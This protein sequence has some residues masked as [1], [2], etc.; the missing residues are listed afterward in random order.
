MRRAAW[1]AL[2]VVGALLVWA[3]WPRGA[4]LEGGA[5]VRGA[6]AGAAAA[7]APRPSASAPS[8]ARGSGATPAA[9][10]PMADETGSTETPLLAR[11]A[12]PRDGFVEI[13]AVAGGK[14]VAGAH[15]RL[16][17][18]G[19][20]DRNTGRTDWRLA[21]MGTSAGDGS[22]RMAAR[23]GAY[24]AAA[25]AA[26]FAPAQRELQRPMGEPVTRVTLEL[27][28]GLSLSGKTVQKGSGEPVPLSLV[29]LAYAVATPGAFRRPDAPA[30]EQ[31]RATSDANGRF[32]FDGLEHGTWRATAQA[33]G[34]AGAAARVEV[35]AQ[36]ELVLELP[37][38]AFI[39][40]QVVGSDGSPGA[41]A[42]V[43]AAGGEDAVTGVASAS[44]TFSLEVPPR[45][46]TVSARHGEES[47][48]AEAPVIVAPGAT[49][50]GV[51]IRLGAA[52]GIV[53][54]V[55]A[56]A[57][58]QPVAGAQIAVSPHDSNG[59]SGRAI[60]DGSG[61]FAV[62]G[63][64]PG[65]YDVAVSAD[66]FSDLS[67]RG[68]TVAAGQRFPLR[69]ELRQEGVV[70]G[71]V[72]DSAGRPVAA[73]LVRAAVARMGGFAGPIP[74]APQEARTDG[75]GAYRLTGVAAGRGSFTALRDG[76]PLGTA[77]VTEV[78]EGGTARLDFQLKD[79][80]MLTGRV[81]R[82]DGSPPPPDAVVS[83]MPA[84]NRGARP[85]WGSLPLDAAGTYSV[86]LPAGA[87]MLSAQSPGRGGFFRS[88]TRATVEAGDTSTQ[89]LVYADAADSG[90][91]FS[92][93]VLE[94]DGTPSP[95]A[96]VRGAGGGRFG[97]IFAANTD[98]SG[99]FDTG[100]QRSDLP[101]AFEVIA[102]NGGRNGRAQVAP[103]QASVTIQLLPGA[104]LR[105]HL[106]GG[107]VDSF[108]VTLSAGGVPFGEQLEFTG[109][110]FEVR[111]VAAAQVHMVVTTSDARSAA[112][113]VTLAPGSTQEVEIPLQPLSS[114]T[115]RIVDA[116]THL[117]LP[118][119]ALL[120]DQGSFRDNRSFSGSDG[121]F[122][123]RIA[124]G[125][126]SLRGFLSGYQ[127]LSK[128]FS[129]TAGQPLEL[130]DVPMQRAVTHGP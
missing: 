32:R 76:S 129:A 99:R 29:T 47:G 127:G 16:Y 61:V 88:R 116:E 124:A 71:T 27:S 45:T 62:G 50:R 46:W 101:D 125:D 108:Q 97:M 30:E 56:A 53:G 89:D 109:D 118:D 114:V 33:A 106:A 112:L 14:P 115:G 24:L 19:P 25:H 93:A 98:E 64:S 75:D 126:H 52:C 111:D 10:N 20:A 21:G 6:P 66:G 26:G 91:G 31:P 94:P 96:S 100:R 120:A 22:A 122:Q 119:V 5:E 128:G 49:R 48:T 23:P 70:E 3:L 17:W 34:Y 41:G 103:Q 121:R 38:A 67:R 44:G 107:A 102:A 37:A 79:E 78:P 84:D 13:R 51:V 12:T 92:G 8:T 54:T 65:S 104:I 95:A 82:K 87:Y 63:L 81:R 74:P 42:E 36:G 59:D 2:P 11:P 83:A 105:G 68:V 28:A 85:Q 40:G 86:S 58:Q 15:L 55:V 7:G 73:A 57:T 60:S 110:R 43:I 90:A 69:V 72:R 77:A 1:L 18:R 113:D 35:P 117:P 130:G 9:A 39:E 80:G 123:L 4:E